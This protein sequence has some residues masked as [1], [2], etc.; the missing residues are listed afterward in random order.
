[1]AHYIK[2]RG[3]SRRGFRVD[4]DSRVN[5]S[6]VAEVDL[7]DA[8]QARHLT[9]NRHQYFTSPEFSIAVGKTGGAATGAIGQ[10][11][12]PRDMVLK[13][14]L[15]TLGVAN[16]GSTFIV[17]V[18]RVAAG[19]LTTAAG[20]TVFTTQSR[21]PTIADGATI[22]G[23]TATNGVP[24]VSALSAGDILRVEVDQVGSGT[25]GSN[26]FVRLNFGLV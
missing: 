8:K 4:S 2:L 16:V 23:L 21:R 19:G 3:F 20:T 7:D 26:L 6:T 13:S 15:A 22:S 18:H 1:M 11:V 25:A 10:I 12:V 9:S 17:D 5:Y 14:V 24:Q